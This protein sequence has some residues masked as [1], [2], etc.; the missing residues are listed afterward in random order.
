MPPAARVFEDPQKSIP[1]A[2]T[3]KAARIT[4]S[5]FLYISGIG[6]Q[7]L[8]LI[9]EEEEA[10]NRKIAHAVVFTMTSGATR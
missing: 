10:I 5:G 7:S 3:Q 2:K 4:P 8:Q 1:N 6:A 9:A